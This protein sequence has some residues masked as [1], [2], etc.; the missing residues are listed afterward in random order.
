MFCFRSDKIR[1][2]FVAVAFAARATC[3]PLHSQRAGKAPEGPG[4][5]GDHAPF[6]KHTALAGLQASFAMSAL[7]SHGLGLRHR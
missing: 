4:K 7:L 3:R 1:P 6:S 2:E 5:V